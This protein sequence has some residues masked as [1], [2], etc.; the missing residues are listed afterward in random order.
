MKL[1][2]HRLSVLAVCS[3][4]ATTSSAVIVSVTDPAGVPLASAMVT[5]TVA[6]PAPRDIA[7]NGYQQPG[8]QRIAE[9]ETTAFTGTAGTARLPDRVVEMQYRVRKPGYQ[10]ALVQARTGQDAIRITLRVETDPFKL[11]EAKPAN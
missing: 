8:Q 9:T 1:R 4:I 10:D 3:A 2:M 6:H 7:D 11:A 5:Q